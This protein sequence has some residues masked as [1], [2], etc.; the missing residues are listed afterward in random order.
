MEDENLFSKHLSYFHT[1]AEQTDQENLL[2]RSQIYSR[3][4]SHFIETISKTKA[5]ATSHLEIPSL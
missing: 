2:F 4:P 3:N 5:K 1:V